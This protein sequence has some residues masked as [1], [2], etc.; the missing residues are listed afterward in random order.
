[1]KRAVRTCSPAPTIGRSSFVVSALAAV[2]VIACAGAAHAQDEPGITLD[3]A[4][5]IA[6]RN[7]PRV[8]ALQ[9][10][11]AEAAGRLVG[12]DTYPFNPELELS[13]AA[14]IGADDTTGDVELGVTQE[15]ELAGQTGKRADTARAELQAVRSDRVR[16]LRLLAGEV[17]LGFIE[18]LQ[19]REMLEIARAEAELAAQLL[20]LA[21]RRLTAGAGTQLDVNVAAAEL[22]RAE[23][24]VGA[25]TG[26]LA[27]ARA[28][29]AET[30]GLPP[31]EL[32]VP[33]GDL[34]PVSRAL[35]PL[36]DLIAAAEANRADLRALRD[37]EHAARA[38]IDLARAEAWPNL[39]VRVFAGREEG[40][41]TLVGAGIAIP[42]PFIQRN[43]GAI[44]EAEAAAAR[45]AAERDAARLS[46]VREVV[47]AYERHQAGL[48]SLAGLR[49]RVLGTTEENLELLRKAFEAGKTGWTDVL[50]MRRALFDARRALIE[51]S[52]QVRRDRVR[53]DVA[54]GRTPLPAGA[55]TE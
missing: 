50:V 16:A 14:R 46:V 4:V 5:E 8:R 10:R 22:G 19:A 6:F 29:L 26:E 49:K 31:S 55:E 35:P 17:H 44:A 23:Q 48:T 34:D 39:R 3:Q 27:A 24:A 37:I 41:D 21:T 43:Q 12:A 2:L 11:V 51:T 36:D 18:A 54:A 20:E 1:M 28:A 15:I 47:T 9:A 13:G 40:T 53:I 30:L 52:A 45:V 33:A 42:L 7:T 25:A 32:P 38:R